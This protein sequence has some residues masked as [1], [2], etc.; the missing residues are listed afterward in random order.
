MI[1]RVK[2]LIDQYNQPIIE[3][4]SSLSYGKVT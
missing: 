3:S 4:S 2:M 1:E